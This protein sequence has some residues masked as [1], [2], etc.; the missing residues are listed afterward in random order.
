MALPFLY[1]NPVRRSFPLSLQSIEV[2]NYCR[3]VELISLFLLNFNV[4]DFS[5]DQVDD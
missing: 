3:S 2:N 1:D 5:F 4:Y